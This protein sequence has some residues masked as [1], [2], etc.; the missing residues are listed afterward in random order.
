M[1]T[2]RDRDRLAGVHPDLARVVEA[3]RA[4]TAF[5][6]V[7]GLRSRQRQA[8]LVAQGKSRTMESRH[9]TGHAVDLAPLVDGKVSWDWKH[10]HPMAA[11][12]KASAVDLGVSIVWGGDW[13]TFPDGPHFELDRRVYP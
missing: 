1:M 4:R 8:Q 9:I 2:A 11:A 5:I 13:K 7:E 10:F 12:V 6:V 3:A